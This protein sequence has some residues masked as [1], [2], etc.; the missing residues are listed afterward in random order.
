[1]RVGRK[2]WRWL[3]RACCM[4]T[5]LLLLLNALLGQSWAPLFDAAQ[6]FFFSR[7]LAPLAPHASASQLAA[8]DHISTSTHSPRFAVAT[9]PSAR[10]PPEKHGR[11]KSP[12]RLGLPR[13]LG[14]LKLVA[15]T[16]EETA[17]EESPAVI[18]WR[19]GAVH[20]LPPPEPTSEPLLNPPL[21]AD[22]VELLPS[23]LPSG[24]AGMAFH[25]LRLDILEIRSRDD[26]LALSSQLSEL[27]LYAGERRIVPSSAVAIGGDVPPK[28]AASMAVDG[29]LETHWSDAAVLGDRGKATLEL[30][31]DRAE[32]ISAY[33]L[34][35][36]AGEPHSPFPP[37]FV[38]SRVSSHPVFRPVFRHIPCF[39]TSRVSS[40]PVFRHIPCFAP[41]ITAPCFGRNVTA[42]YPQRDPTS[43]AL[44]GAQAEAGDERGERVGEKDDTGEGTRW[45]LLD[46]QKPFGGRL[47]A[48]LG[49]YGRIALEHGPLTAGSLSS[50]PASL[51]SMRPLPSGGDAW[52]PLVLYD[53][54]GEGWRVWDHL[55]SLEHLEGQIRALNASAAISSLLLFSEPA[56]AGRA[57]RLHLG[58]AGSAAALPEGLGVGVRSL[59]L[60]WADA[61]AVWIYGGEG[62]GAG[63]VQPFARSMRHETSEVHA[64]SPTLA[65]KA[66]C[67]GN[68]VSGALLYPG[69]KLRGTPT[70]LWRVAGARPPS[71]VGDAMVGGAAAGAAAGA[72]GGTA[73]GTAEG[74]AALGMAALAGAATSPAALAALAPS[75]VA[76]LCTSA[77]LEP[78]VASAHLALLIGESDALLELSGGT[79]RLVRTSLATL[80]DWILHSDTQKAPAVRSVC[81]GTSVR[82]LALFAAEGWRGRLAMLTRAEG[83]CAE[84]AGQEALATLDGRPP[85]SL[86][87]I[88]REDSAALMGGECG[89]ARAG[90]ELVVSADMPN[91]SLLGDANRTTRARH[92]HSHLVFGRAIRGVVLYRRANFRGAQLLVLARSKEGVEKEEGT[93]E[94]AGG[95][96]ET[97]FALP[98]QW[99]DEVHSIVLL[100]RRCREGGG[101]DGRLGGLIGGRRAPSELGLQCTRQA[102]A[103]ARVA[104]AETA[105]S[106]Q[107][108]AA[109]T[110]R[111]KVPRPLQFS[112]Q[113]ADEGAM[114]PLRL[115]ESAPRGLAAPLA[116]GAHGHF[117][118][119][120]P[121]LL[122]GEGDRLWL[123]ARH[124]NYH[125]CPN[126]HR[127]GSGFKRDF[128]ANLEEANGAIMSF[129]LA[130]ELD[131]A[132]WNLTSHRLAQD[133]GA[134]IG[135][136]GGGARGVTRGGA[137]AWALLSELNALY[138]ALET[139]TVS[140]PEDPRVIETAGGLIFFIAAWDSS[141]VQWQHA[142]RF[143]DA[144]PAARAG[145]AR[146]GAPAAAA[147]E[148]TR[149]SALLRRG[150]TARPSALSRR[151]ELSERFVHALRPWF[152]QLRAS[153]KQ[154]RL[155]EKNWSPFS[156]GGGIY[157][158]YSIE[159]RLV[160]SLNLETGLATPLFP[161]TSSPA[162]R[163]WLERLGPVSGGTPAVYVAGADLFLA[164]AHV[165]RFA[166][167]GSSRTAT[168]ATVYKHFW[169]TFEPRPPFRILGASTPFTLPSRFEHRAKGTSI[170]AR[171]LQVS[172]AFAPYV[173]PHTSRPIRHAPYVTPHTSHPIR[174][175]P[176]V[177]PHLSRI[178]PDSQCAK[179][180][181][182]G[183]LA[184]RGDARAAGE[185]W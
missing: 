104:A 154:T 26:P 133:G 67:I 32:R 157:L 153:H 59:R 42:E 4:G 7:E 80:G 23:F 147:E 46:V 84:L 6:P 116:A 87:L 132:S 106:A 25:R 141:R 69:S 182:H 183:A 78:T 174:H 110:I 159:P 29:K 35:A 63:G 71:T 48:R 99:I 129:V 20:P 66:L 68:A 161:I 13:R 103:E 125:F 128:E 120:N 57:T 142:V 85:R 184:A 76:P 33:E 93:G 15:L 143:E 151:L 58:K 138:P 38:T 175:T 9:H 74:T 136:G 107:A 121:V 167:R 171:L 45:Q 160:L 114:V 166:K 156:W 65:P 135:G 49:S 178:S 97:C 77:S 12:G 112:T 11:L 81:L 75:A 105:A 155:R 185:L 102:M 89:A 40:H 139:S 79:H 43:W 176:Y 134:D 163:A 88:L 53:T 111:R 94:G 181:R 148:E 91:L 179:P 92:R 39:V 51:P 34:V 90:E 169:Y 5:V 60:E 44:W 115:P 118:T 150:G 56:F 126:S 73:G 47:P 168:S 108:A 30:A 61:G 98:A 62:G 55:P 14:R 64:R 86:R 37:P 24:N 17:S 170:Q 22:V 140:G 127:N 21:E 31:F 1:M 162:V 145:A 36:A 123:V 41:L 82:A 95:A 16:R 146:S 18:A 83:G 177:T 119:Y 113:G 96:L 173:T 72:A 101:R 149:G 165:K 28:H 117:Y 54:L 137:D 158:E 3:L 19:T 180:V 50:A 2:G 8:S 109:V 70:L 52:S 10:T 27:R 144:P 131:G 152:P 124:S 130:A 100:H 164:L 172:C 122:P